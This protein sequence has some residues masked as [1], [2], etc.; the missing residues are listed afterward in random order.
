MA[1]FT[2]D[3]NRHACGHDGHTTMLLAAAKHLAETR[4]FA[5]TVQTIFQPAEEGHFGG[6]KM[7][8]DGAATSSFLG[9][10]FSSSF[11]AYLSIIS[12]NQSSNQG[13]LIAYWIGACN[14]NVVMHS[15]SSGLFERFPCDE[16]YGVTPKHLPPP[17]PQH[18]PIHPPTQSPPPT[19]PP[20]AHTT[21]PA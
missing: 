16:V 6:L 1:F 8:E 2:P 20:H 10:F 19:R 21:A 15:R 9:P 17:A 5:G 4:N 14:S 18:H 11:L 3:A 7:V 13:E 12:S